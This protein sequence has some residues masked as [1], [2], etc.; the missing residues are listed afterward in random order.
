MRYAVI[1]VS[2]A[3]A[4]S[5]SVGSAWAVCGGTHCDYTLTWGDPISIDSTVE[6]VACEHG[7]GYEKDIGV[8]GGDKDRGMHPMGQPGCTLTDEIDIT[9]SNLDAS[10]GVSVGSP[11]FGGAL[12]RRDCFSGEPGSY[13]HIIY[14]LEDKDICDGAWGGSGDDQ[15]RET[16]WLSCTW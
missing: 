15:Y 13:V 5:M 9:V 2:V 1:G 11:H 16:D 7:C 3:C 4:L 14:K 10:G 6:N 12:W 8:S